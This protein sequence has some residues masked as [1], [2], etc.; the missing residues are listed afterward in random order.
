MSGK[1]A[2]PDTRELQP[3]EAQEF[4][5]RRRLKNR[6]LIVFALAALALVVFHNPRAWADGSVA[7]VINYGAWLALGVGVLVM[8]WADVKAAECHGYCRG[9]F[10]LTPMELREFG[11]DDRAD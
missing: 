2:D 9:K 11:T 5:K 3:A 6:A 7:T 1:T 8:Y 10:D 4:W